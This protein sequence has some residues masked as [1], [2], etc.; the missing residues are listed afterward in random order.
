MNCIYCNNPLNTKSKVC[1][2]CNKPVDSNN[3][4]EPKKMFSKKSWIAIGVLIGAIVIIAVMS[5]NNTF[6]SS[7]KEELIRQAVEEAKKTMTLPTQIDEVTT[8]VD[9]TAETTAIRYHYLLSGMDMST[10][11]EEY[12]KDFLASSMC[13]NPDTKSLLDQ[14]INMEYS[15]VD[16]ATEQNLF[17]TLTKQDCVTK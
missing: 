10:L 9:I 5:R 16:E 6:D 4:T 1:S 15:Y 2:K 12:L 11:T 14:G 17:T 13:A 3:S 8:L 7:A